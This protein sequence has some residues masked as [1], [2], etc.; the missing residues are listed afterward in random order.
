MSIVG[1]V[2]G[3]N[4]IAILTQGIEQ[5][6]LKSL[7]LIHLQVIL[8]AI[9]DVWNNLI[10][11]C[12][13]HIFQEGEE[14]INRLFVSELNNLK[15]GEVS[16]WSLLVSA[17]QDAANIPNANG[18]RIGRQPDMSLIL[19]RRSPNLPF[20]I[21]C[22]IISPE[23]R[24]NLYCKEGLARFVE[25]EYA[26]YDKQ[27][28]MLAY[29]QDQSTIQNKLIPYLKKWQDKINDRYQTT[30]LPLS[31]DWLEKNDL[32][33]SVHHRNFQYVSHHASCVPGDIS[34]WHLW[35][36]PPNT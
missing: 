10:R 13:V 11:V 7:N 18:T 23:K 28:I 15:N 4:Q 3:E 21:E 30:K 29:V 20:I 19:S 24:V 32:A 8:E 2:S 27:S 25:G 1:L 22:K 35:L 16:E 31:I 9:V 17:V 36:N 26:W 6:P 14:S 33:K 12:D 5:L 34:V